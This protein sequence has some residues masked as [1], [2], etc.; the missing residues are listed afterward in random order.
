M[1]YVVGSGP[2]GVS[3]AF[4][5]LNQGVEITLLDVGVELEQERKKRVDALNALPKSNWNPDTIRFLREKHKTGAGGIPLK[6]VYGSDFHYRHTSTYNPVEANGTQVLSSFAKGGLS[7]VW[8]ASV[9]PYTQ[10]ELNEWP[11]TEEELKKHYEA[12]HTWMPLSAC[13]DNLSEQFPLYAK[14]LHPL[15]VSVQAKE[16]LNDLTAHRQALSALGI[17]FGQARLAVQNNAAIGHACVYCSLC[18]YGCPHRLIYSTEQSFAQLNQYAS[19]RYMPGFIVKTVEE[20]NGKVFIH[21]VSFGSGEEKL[22]EAEKVFLACGALS[23]TKILLASMRS[24]A[25][26]VELKTSQHFLI[27]I[28]RRHSISEIKKQEAHTLAQLFLELEDKTVSPHTVHMQLYSYMDFFEET[29]RERLRGL[30]PFFKGVL[31]RYFYGRFLLLQGYLHSEESCSIRLQLNENGVIRAEPAENKRGKPVFKNIVRKMNGIRSILKSFPVGIGAE[32]SPA[33]VGA[34]VGGTFPMRKTPGRFETDTLGRPVGFEHV[35]AIDSSVFPTIP[36]TTITYT[37][38]ANA[39]R[40]A[41]E[42]IKKTGA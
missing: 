29:M 17:L 3:A 35:H 25:E 16:V 28:I 36:A 33:G 32:L 39:H 4:A 18:M 15:N 1:I 34:H 6:Y 5:L 41:S 14:E 27:P 23:T 42:A 12:V 19:F 9:L 10:K 20:K 7:N 22:F 38:M 24:F 21:A 40:I 30:Y 31:D 13:R 11:I 26:A 37:I 8:G 2:A